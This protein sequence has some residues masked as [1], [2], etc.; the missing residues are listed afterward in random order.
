MTIPTIIM[1][2]IPILPLLLFLLPLQNMLAAETVD[3]VSSGVSMRLS[4]VHEN[5]SLSKIIGKD[6]PQAASEIPVPHFAIHTP[7]NKFILT[8]GGQINPIIGVDMGND[9]YRQNGAGSYF[10]TNSIPVPS[11][12][13]KR[14]DFFINPY[15]SA[16]DLQVVGM[17]GT[18]DQ[19]TGYLKFGTDGNSANVTIHQAYVSWKG[20]TAGKKLTLMQDQN[21]CQ[22]PTIDPEGPSGNVSNFAYELS[23]V[24]PSFHGFRCAIGLDLPSY[25]TSSGRYLGNDFRKWESKEVEGQ[26]VCDPTYYNQDIPDIPLWVEWSASE[27]N[28]VR[29]TGIIRNF[30][31][32]DLISESKKRT[33]GWG[34]MLSGNLNPVNPLVLYLQAVYGKGI[35]AYIQDIAG[36]P[37]S[38]IPDDSHPGKMTATPMAA[39]NFGATYNFSSRWQANAVVSHTRIWD[40]GEYAS[41][42]ATEPGN[43][44]NYR[45]AVYAAANVFFNISSYFQVGLEYL[46]GSR[47]TW[48][49]GSAS[50][51]RLQTQFMLTF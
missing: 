37:L 12:A 48:G 44:N 45:Y 50:D 34:V 8:I 15:N 23:Y 5:K 30:T 6:R 14:S 11:L 27:N 24:S 46:Y 35:G 29:L 51:N 26:T 40:V 36:L 28:R 9:L 43:F 7:D 18:S 20:L 21:A 17:G 3:S 32:R 2:R 1:K 19:I 4:K 49:S 25:S 16:I 33:L 13:G 42:A 10:V 47:A 31:Y 38:F 39:L 22:P 41:I